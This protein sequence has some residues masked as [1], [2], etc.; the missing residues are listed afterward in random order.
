MTICFGGLSSNICYNSVI[1]SNP[2]LLTTSD[3]ALA[4]PSLE[5]SPLE[6]LQNISVHRFAGIPNMK[7]IINTL[8]TKLQEGELAADQQYL[9]FQPLRADELLKIDNELQ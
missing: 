1:M 7:K 2:S 4:S 6:E 8:S 9:I 3:S 5:D